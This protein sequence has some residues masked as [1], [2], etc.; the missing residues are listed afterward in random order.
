M[1]DLPEAK[2]EDPSLMDGREWA[3][4]LLLLVLLGAN[5]T[6]ETIPY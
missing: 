2:P 4:R 3:C 6:I 1:S 5:F